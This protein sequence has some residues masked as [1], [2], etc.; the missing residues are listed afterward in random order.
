MLKARALEG[1][2]ADTGLDVDHCTSRSCSRWIGLVLGPVEV[3]TSADLTLPSLP[4]W[5]RVTTPCSHL[6]L[7]TFSSLSMTSEPTANLPP[8]LKFLTDGGRERRYSLD[9]TDQNFDRRFSRTRALSDRTRDVTEV[10]SSTT[11]EENPV[12]LPVRK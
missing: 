3:R 7:G 11:R 8:G 6:I 5:S 12:P 4:M 1:L 9:Q 2:G 10:G